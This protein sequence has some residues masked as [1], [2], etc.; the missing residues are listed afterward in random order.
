MTLSKKRPSLHPWIYIIMQRSNYLNDLKQFIMY[1]GQETKYDHLY[2]VASEWHA[3]IGDI[4]SVA[5][6]L[7]ILLQ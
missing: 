1:F 5:N 3:I 7:I 4:I 6:R 2:V